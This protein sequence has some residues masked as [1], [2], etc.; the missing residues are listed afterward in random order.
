[1]RCA[2]FRNALA[3][4]PKPKCLEVATM[5]KVIHAIESHYASE[6]KAL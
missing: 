6:A 4:V 1:M 5:P 3:K 2:L